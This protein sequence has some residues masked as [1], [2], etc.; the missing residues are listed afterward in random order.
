M[1][2]HDDGGGCHVAIP[3]FERSTD[4]RAECTAPT[5]G[6]QSRRVGSTAW[7]RREGSRREGS[8]RGGIKTRTDRRR[9]VL[10]CRDCGQQLAQ[11]VGRCPGCRAWGTIEE[12]TFGGTASAP[13]DVHPLVAEPGDDR[14]VS[15][16]IAGVDRVLG[17]GLVPAAVALL[18]G[19]PGIGKSTLLLQLVDAMS[20]AGLSCLLASGEESRQQV[21]ARA[22]RLGIDG[23]RISFVPGRELPAVLDAAGSARPFLLAVDSVQTLRDPAGTQVPGGPAQ[24]RACADALVGLAKSDGIAVLLTGHVTKDGDVAGPRTLEHAVDVVLTFDGDPRSGLRVLSGAKNRFGPDGEVAWF[25]MGGNGL[26]E[27]DP[28]TLLLPG[29]GEA[30]AAVALPRAGRRALAVEVQGL[31]APTE[32][33][34]RRQVTGLDP[35]RFQ[36][37]AAVLDRAGWRVGRSDLFGASAGGVRVDDPACDLAVAAA[38]AS[39]ATGAPA[40]PSCAFVGEIGLT[41]MVRPAPSMGSRVAAARSAGIRTVFG[42]PDGETSPDVRL[43]PVRHVK[44]ALTWAAAAGAGRRGRSVDRPA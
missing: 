16:G 37:V 22:T 27:I 43:V 32:S 41:G 14:R 5:R 36:L 35:R 2:H 25:E 20:S 29:E 26:R 28:G 34:P 33:P 19:E 44:D 42:P 38:L 6:C 3:P 39:A 18:A 21:A 23:S 7:A 31:V 11:W 1:R 13:L 15:T 10:A 30:G 9:N 8:R 17:G 4:V 24:V 40:P 12:R